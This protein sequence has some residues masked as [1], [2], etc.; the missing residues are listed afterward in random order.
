MAVG[1]F[2]AKKNS[3]RTTFRNR[4]KRLKSTKKV[5]SREAILNYIA[6]Y[7][8]PISK[9][10]LIQAFQLN[11]DNDKQVLNYRLKAML[12]DHQLIKNRTH[13][14]A[15]PAELSLVKGYVQATK[16]SI[17]FLIPDDGSDDIFLPAFEMRNLL[18][19]DIILAAVTRFNQRRNQREGR[20]VEIISHDPKPLIGR[21]YCEKNIS[22]VEPCD[23][24]FTHNICISENHLA[25]KSGQYV[26]F[27]LSATPNKYL[28][29]AG[30]LIKI[31][32]ETL[33]PGLE[34]K[35]AIHTNHLPHVFSKAQ[36]KEANACQTIPAVS[37]AV[38][39]DLT[40]LNFVTIDDEDA[41]DFDDAVFCDTHKN[42]W[43][44][45]AA[46]ADVSTYVHPET[47]IDKE[48]YLRGTSVYFANQVIPMLP[49]VL[50]NELCS[51]TPNEKKLTLVCQMDIDRQGVIKHYDFYSAVVISK[52]R[53]T[54]HEVNK[55]L[56]HKQH[57]LIHELSNLY[58]VYKKLL[59]QRQIRGAI[60]FDTLD[61]KIIFNEKGKIKQIIPALRGI[62]HRMIEETMLA[63]NVCAAKFLSKHKLP[64]L[65]RNHG[66]PETEKVKALR[67]FLM[68]FGLRL[69]GYPH[70]KSS[71]YAKLIKRIRNRK[72]KYLLQTVLLR[73]LS[74]AHYSPHQ[75][76]HFG[77]AYHQYTHF[78]SP[79]R[80][81]PD[82]M[83]HRAIKS[84]LAQNTAL[85]PYCLDALT[86]IGQ[87]CSLTE[88]RAEEASRN[89]LN[90][91]K[92]YAMQSRVGGQF[93]GIISGVTSFGLFV[94]LNDIYVEG[95]VHISMLKNDYY[96]YDDKRHLLYGK[97]RGFT[98]RLGDA[99]TVLVMR[100]DLDNQEIDLQII[101]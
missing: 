53:L 93:N 17:G 2:M 25:A 7:N 80:R 89:A 78:T 81:Y 42:G 88:K 69:T 99:V 98:Y 61:T 13:H 83:I 21:F 10:N 22:F 63:T 50:S 48:A 91:L 70:P 6:E 27:K 38:H 74:Q 75:N 14:Y 30:T 19:N 4:P 3:N 33:T 31:L 43:R 20:L 29:P 28:Q 41:K 60:D 18:N 36:L 37:A 16:E 26:L 23:R 49:S 87:H 77:L 32:G 79:I 9:S 8:I 68:P 58:Q 54:Y 47:L 59:H 85:Y 95:L 44:L 45:Y 100:V 84:I 39:K 46:I 1:I 5:P 35:I 62:S 67:E 90:W 72:D 51:L 12:R 56:E 52:A 24:T 55:I 82:L 76:G 73:S 64:F 92:C 40:A 66:S 65:Y 86:R 96:G 57:V 97:R 71:D 11:C 101:S 34:M 94:E 15:I